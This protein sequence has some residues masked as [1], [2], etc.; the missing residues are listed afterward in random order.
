MILS[1]E[2]IIKIQKKNKKQKT[3]KQKKQQKT[4]QNKNS[5]LYFYLCT[6]L[7]IRI[8]FTLSFKPLLN[9]RIILFKD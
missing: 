7:M 2:D 1:N 3:K 6:P 9:T 5:T 4:K 8:L